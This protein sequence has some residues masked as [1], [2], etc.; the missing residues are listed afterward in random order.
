M[1][2]RDSAVDGGNYHCWNRQFDSLFHWIPHGASLRAFCM[3]NHYHR[4]AIPLGPR[5]ESR[6]RYQRSKIHRGYWEITL[7]R[8]TQLRWYRIWIFHWREYYAILRFVLSLTAVSSGHLLQLTTTVAF[9][10]THR[11]W[12]YSCWP[13]LASSYLLF[14]S[15]S[16]GP[17]WWLLRTKIM[18]M[19]SRT[20][21]QVAYLAKSCRL[22]KVEEN[23]SSSF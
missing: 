2:S 18:L 8:Y 10:P 14:L 22:G 9:P 15:K 12:K 17:L 11:L 1:E 13:F 7:L 19:L 23:L 20:V 3:D 4:N 6:I 5:S 16:W 21:G